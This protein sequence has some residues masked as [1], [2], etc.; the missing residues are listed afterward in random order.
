MFFGVEWH[1]RQHRPEHFFLGDAHVGGHVAEYCRA[2]ELPGTVGESL[3]T[4]NCHGA[5]FDRPSAQGFNTR[6]L[7]GA[8]DRGE[9]GIV[10]TQP[11]TQPFSH[12]DHGRDHVFINL[13]LHQQARHRRTDLAGIEENPRLDAGEQLL[14][15]RIG[16]GNCSRFTT[17]FHH[18]RNRMLRGITQNRLARRHGT[19][20]H[21]LVDGS[22]ADQVRT[23]FTTSPTNQVDRAVRQASLGNGADQHAHAQR[24]KLGGL[25]HDRVTR[26][27]SRRQRAG[28][29]R[30]R[31]I[32]RHDLRRN[33]H[34]VVQGEV[35]VAVAQ[36]NRSAL[37]LVGHAGVI[38]E[39]AR[40]LDE[41]V[42]GVAQALAVFLAQHPGALIR[43]GANLLGNAQQPGDA[44]RRT[45][46]SQHAAVGTTTSCQQRTLGIGHGG[47]GD[48]RDRF[49]SAGV[50]HRQALDAVAPLPVDVVEPVR[51][52]RIHGSAPQADGVVAS[53]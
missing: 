9:V 24:R 20:E 53:N 4:G 14:P 13:A 28:A 12:G 19:G 52:Y 30:H 6:Q 36:R 10:L 49:G 21:D 25:D 48:G 16:E 50:V 43:H 46:A 31:E 32:P 47:L 22:M 51:G 41:L 3:A 27:Q 44:L 37:D 29:D 2:H 40:R 35:H 15:I 7:P 11:D 5:L 42:P 26:R 8:D 33:A 18:A 38:L 34:R 1:D 23:D 45:G 17:Q 39:V